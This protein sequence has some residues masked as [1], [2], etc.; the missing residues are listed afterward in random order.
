MSFLDEISNIL[1]TSGNGGGVLG[2]VENTINSMIKDPFGSL[3]MIGTAIF[4]P[5]MLPVVAGI[6][7]AAHGGNVLAI[8]KAAGIAYLGQQVLSYASASGADPVV[9]TDQLTNLLNNMDGLQSSI[10]SGVINGTDIGQL[11]TSGWDASQI[12]TVLDSGGTASQLTALDNAGWQPNSVVGSL[13]NGY[14]VDNLTTFADAGLS[15]DSINNLASANGWTGHD[16]LSMANNGL[17][18]GQIQSY[19]GLTYSQAQDAID[20]GFGNASEYVNAKRNK[21]RRCWGRIRLLDLLG[22]FINSQFL[23]FVFK[24]I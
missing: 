18:A 6:N 14:T 17:D 8:A 3:A 10:D 1:G 2:F 23:Y 20:G 9:P 15:P 22:Y 24:E 19:S 7:T 12:N 13:S 4:A 21:T 5:E 16:I 11:T